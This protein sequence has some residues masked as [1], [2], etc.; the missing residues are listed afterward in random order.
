[1]IHFRSDGIPTARCQK[2]DV[3]SN[4]LVKVQEDDLYLVKMQ[5]VTVDFHTI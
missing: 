3:N 1:M 2:Q 5:E 4:N